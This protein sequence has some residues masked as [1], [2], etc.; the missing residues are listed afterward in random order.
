MNARKLERIRWAQEVQ[1]LPE[2]YDVEDVSPPAEFAVSYGEN[3]EARP[4]ERW[5]VAAGRTGVLEG[6][7]KPMPGEPFTELYGRRNIAERRFEELSQQLI[8]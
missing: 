5:A 8:G 6:R 3:P 1:I 4:S 7:Q 2:G